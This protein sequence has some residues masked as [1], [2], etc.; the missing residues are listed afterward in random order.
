MLNLATTH[1]FAWSRKQPFSVS[2]DDLFACDRCD[3]YLEPCTRKTL[4]ATVEQYLVA[5]HFG[6]VLDRGF[7]VMLAQNRLEDLARLYR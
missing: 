6:T 7:E 4:V 2:I 5:R 1:P 3:V